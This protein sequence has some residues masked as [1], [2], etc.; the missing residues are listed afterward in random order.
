MLLVPGHLYL[1]WSVVALVVPLLFSVAL[2]G[3]YT[4]LR[5]WWKVLGGMG[6]VLA[7]TGL[8]VALCGSVWGRVLPVADVASVC[9][10]LGEKGVPTY[11]LDWVTYPCTALL[12]IGVAVLRLRTLG[13][14]SAVPLV[15]GLFGWIFYVTDF[16]SARGMIVVNIV[17]ASLFGLSWVALGCILWTRR[18]TPRGNPSGVR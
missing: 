10:F 4:M 2:V 14:W 8:F 5:G 3:L 1:V 6:L 9:G 7:G 12:T 16:G 13:R 18:R 17:F 15:G 11:M